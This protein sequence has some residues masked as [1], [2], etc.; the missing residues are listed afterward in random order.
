MGPSKKTKSHGPSSLSRS[1]VPSPFM[2][3]TARLYWDWSINCRA[4]MARSASSSSVVIIPPSRRYGAICKAEYP[5]QVPISKT[6]LGRAAARI[7]RNKGSSAPR[8]IGSS[9]SRAY[10]SIS[11]HKRFT[12]YA[13]VHYPYVRHRSWK[14]NYAR[15]HQQQNTSTMYPAP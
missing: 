13:P 8:R 5:I 6:C 10:C 14:N 3:V 2:T 12:A 15:S 9:C 7:F 4:V 1:A 11:R